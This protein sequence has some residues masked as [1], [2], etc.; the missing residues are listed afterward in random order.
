MR[1]F[2]EVTFQEQTCLTSVVDGPNPSW[3]AELSLSFTYMQFSQQDMTET[4]FLFVCVDRSP[5][6][7][8]SPTGLQTVPDEIHFNLFDELLI[9]VLDDDRERST[10]RHERIERRWLGSFSIPF[11]TVYSN[12]RVSSVC[13]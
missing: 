12:T 6:N 5:N 4:D 11:S 7:D 3:N 8:Y 13:D 9:D 2:V 10:T 1:P